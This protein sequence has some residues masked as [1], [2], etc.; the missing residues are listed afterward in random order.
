[1]SIRRMLV[2]AVLLGLTASMT[3]G[4]GDEKDQ[5]IRWPCNLLTPAEVKDALGMTVVEKDLSADEVRASGIDADVTVCRWSAGDDVVVEMQTAQTLDLFA[6]YAADE[7]AASGDQV[8][9][10][11]DRP[12]VLDEPAFDDP[13][14]GVGQ[15]VLLANLGRS[16]GVQCWLPNG[17]PAPP[18]GFCLGLAKKAMSRVKDDIDAGG[19][20]A[21]SRACDLITDDEV[22]KLSGLAAAANGGVEEPTSG[23]RA[24][25]ENYACTWK[26]GDTPIVSVRAGL[27]IVSQCTGPA[28][29]DMFRGGKITYETI[30]TASV[31]LGSVKGEYCLHVDVRTASGGLTQAEARQLYKKALDR[32]DGE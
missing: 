18:S 23:G 16:L 5:F 1:M 14:G 7:G 30:D 32:L 15:T 22:R 11:R 12:L 10:G 21:P 8:L 26:D 2:V 31:Q 19:D 13:G 25:I 24:G 4:C 6:A 27:R 17:H 29:Q 20:V 3:T 9:A 28:G